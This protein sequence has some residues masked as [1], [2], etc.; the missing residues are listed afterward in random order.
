[1][2]F[3]ARG[4]QGNVGLVETVLFETRVK[5]SIFPTLGGSLGDH[6]REKS[7]KNRKKNRNNLFKIFEIFFLFFFILKI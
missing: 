1:M 6:K 2:I 4:M 3:L 5:K 7:K